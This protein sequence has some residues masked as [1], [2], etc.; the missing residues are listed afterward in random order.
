MIIGYILTIM[1]SFAVIREIYL[2][3]NK[4]PHLTNFECWIIF[5]LS[6]LSFFSVFMVFAYYT[7]KHNRENGNKY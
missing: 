4:K 5:F 3:E 1:F 2:D 7:I 6:I